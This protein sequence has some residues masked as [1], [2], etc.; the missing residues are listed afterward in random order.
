MRKILI[1]KFTFL[2]VV[3]TAATSD[4]PRYQFSLFVTMLINVIKFYRIKRLTSLGLD[5]LT[6]FKVPRL[7]FNYTIIFHGLLLDFK[8]TNPKDKTWVKVNMYSIVCGK[9]RRLKNKQYSLE[10]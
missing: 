5:V 6:S 2:P 4:F 1:L 3:L 10:I 9:H 8:K 7:S